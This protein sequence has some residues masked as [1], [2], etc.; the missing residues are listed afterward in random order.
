M[1]IYSKHTSWGLEGRGWGG[2]GWG[3]ANGT[4]RQMKIFA[5]RERLCLL[6]VCIRMHHLYYA[7]R[8]PGGRARSLTALDIRLPRSHTTTAGPL[9]QRIGEVG[10]VRAVVIS[11]W[12][13]CVCGGGGGSYAACSSLRQTLTLVNL[14]L[15]SLLPASW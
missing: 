15:V 3:E 13:V 6:A 5:D 7:S 12:C 2:G 9:L 4:M 1:F 11:G 8:S 14:W 10:G